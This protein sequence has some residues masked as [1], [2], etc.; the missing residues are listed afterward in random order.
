[1]ILRQEER[2]SSIAPLW[3]PQLTL[4]RWAQNTDIELRELFEVLAQ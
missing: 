2:G 4:A 3:T 1:M